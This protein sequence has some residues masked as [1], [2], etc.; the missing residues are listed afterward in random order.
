MW[1][2]QSGTLDLC[3]AVPR[4]LNGQI[5]VDSDIKGRVASRSILSHL[6]PP[7]T[8]AAQQSFSEESS[9]SDNGNRNSKQSKLP[10]LSLRSVPR[11]VCDCNM[12]VSP[13]TQIE[14]FI[15]HFDKHTGKIL[16]V[17]RPLHL[18]I[19]LQKWWRNIY[20][21]TNS[22]YIIRFSCLTTG[23]CAPPCNGLLYG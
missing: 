21:H 8:K 2:V 13:S 5:I 20:K 15:V 7:A 17:C 10:Q 19:E 23:T 18:F 9:P 22:V 4:V 1:N 6:K 14:G 11:Q 3:S 16:C 12:V